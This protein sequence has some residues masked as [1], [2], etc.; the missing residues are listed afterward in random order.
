[1][2]VVSESVIQHPDNRRPAAVGDG[3][4]FVFLTERGGLIN[5]EFRQSRLVRGSPA[6]STYTSVLPCLAHQSAE[7]TAVLVLAAAVPP[8]HR[9]APPQP[10]RST[11]PT[12]H[13]PDDCGTRLVGVAIARVRSQGFKPEPPVMPKG[14]MATPPIWMPRSSRSRSSQVPFVGDPSRSSPALCVARVRLLSARRGSRR[15]S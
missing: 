5:L 2:G 7:A 9:S 8:R 6:D 13:D 1:M 12:R 4:G 15:Y 10:R 11:T 3:S 14:V